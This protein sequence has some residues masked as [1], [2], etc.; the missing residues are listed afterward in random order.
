M[1]LTNTDV[2]I[3]YEKIKTD[4]HNS[5]KNTLTEYG[6]THTSVDKS[7]I[8]ISQNL[9][10]DFVA[11]YFGIDLLDLTDRYWQFELFENT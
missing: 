10:R 3:N 7:N 2:D 6:Y 8:W 4:I 9:W 1:L 11:A 5:Y